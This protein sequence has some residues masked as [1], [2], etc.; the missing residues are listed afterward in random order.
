[1]RNNNNISSYALD[2]LHLTPHSLRSRKVFPAIRTIC[3]LFTY[4]GMRLSFFKCHWMA[5]SLSSWL[6][7]IEYV[8]P[9]C[10]RQPCHWYWSGLLARWR[11]LT[12]GMSSVLVSAYWL[13]D[14]G[15]S[16]ECHRVWWQRTD[17]SKLLLRQ[18]YG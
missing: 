12:F 5:W 16:L 18:S 6:D 1:M 10:S 3:A 11:R 15:A 13:D 17:T 14:K 9:L 2:H 4:W 7:A 8:S